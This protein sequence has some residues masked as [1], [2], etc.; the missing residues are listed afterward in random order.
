MGCRVIACCVG[1]SIVWAMPFDDSTISAVK[2]W[3]ELAGIG[4]GYLLKV[5]TG[6]RLNLA[7]DPGQISRLPKPIAVETDFHSKQIS[8]HSTRIGAAQDL[9]DSGANIGQIM[10]K[11]RRSKIDTVM[12][13]VGVNSHSLSNQNQ[14]ANLRVWLQQNKY[15]L[16]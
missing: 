12:R 1:L 14:I 6:N 8:R 5:I 2:Y 13:Y 10:A 3:I 7:M 15:M 9:L 11:L 4:D 16:S